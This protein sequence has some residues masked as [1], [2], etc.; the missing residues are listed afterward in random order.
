MLLKKG[1]PELF[2]MAHNAEDW[3]KIFTQLLFRNF[4]EY[5]GQGKFAVNWKRKCINFI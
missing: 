1:S 3:D 4:I 2:N 5:L